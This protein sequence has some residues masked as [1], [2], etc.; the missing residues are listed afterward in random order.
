MFNAVARTYAGNSDVAFFAVS[1]DDDEAQVPAFVAR[2]K[3]DVPV[4]YSDGLGAFTKSDTLPNILV[5]GRNGEILYRT[6]GFPRE[7]FGDSLTAAIQAAVDA[8]H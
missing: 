6:G 5:L 1:T 2:E 4:V 8:A 7:Q 3:W